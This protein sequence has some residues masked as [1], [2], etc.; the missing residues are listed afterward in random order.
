MNNYRGAQ[1]ICTARHGTSKKK[2]SHYFVR[3]IH[4]CANTVILL[5]AIFFSSKA[6]AQSSVTLSLLCS[7]DPSSIDPKP[8]SRYHRITALI[9]F[10][11][12]RPVDKWHI[13]LAR[14]SQTTPHQN[15]KVYRPCQPTVG[16][17]NNRL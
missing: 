17:P 4:A 7:D 3:R 14:P 2:R 1:A 12:S 13:F 11:L 5:L 9:I 16:V 15:A 6:Q 10:I 8:I